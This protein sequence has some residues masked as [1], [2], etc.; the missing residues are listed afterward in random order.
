[1]EINQLIT[2]N[3]EVFSAFE[4]L[5]SQLSDNIKLTKE[6]LSEVINSK[7][8]Y[9]FVAEEDGEIIGILTLITYLIPSGRKSW[10]EDV[11]V[12]NNIRGKGI[13]RK[14]VQHAIDHASAMGITKI[15]LTSSFER[16][17]T[18]ELYQKMG[19]KKRDTNVYRLEIN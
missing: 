10:I 1:M 18:N 7:D 12:N 13:G 8:T 9:I 14:L 16:V 5:L 4:K 2:V 15:D 17:A 11:V 19:F 6:N 3:H